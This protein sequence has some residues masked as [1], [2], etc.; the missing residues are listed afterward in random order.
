MIEVLKSIA[1]LVRTCLEQTWVVLQSV[2]SLACF[3]LIL[4]NVEDMAF[5][6]DIKETFVV[7]I[8][9]RK[10]VFANLLKI[11]YF[12]GIA[13]EGLN[14]TTSV[15]TCSKPQNIHLICEHW[16]PSVNSHC[17]FDVCEVVPI[18][19]SSG[20]WSIVLVNILWYYKLSRWWCKESQSIR[21]TVACQI[22]WGDLTYLK[23]TNNK[24][25]SF[26][27]KKYFFYKNA[28]F[29][30][31]LKVWFPRY[32]CNWKWMLHLREWQRHQEIVKSI[33]Y[34]MQCMQVPMGYSHICP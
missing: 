2:H 30:R 16:C 8:Q 28:G 6:S 26:F 34:R 11:K 20:I 23:K 4:W 18:Y 33:V 7:S 14:C 31:R 25:Y 9:M 21:I 19:T 22:L 27:I 29:I 13:Y 17:Y 32:G 10:F 5:N 24:L 3:A 1:N 12:Y 15:L